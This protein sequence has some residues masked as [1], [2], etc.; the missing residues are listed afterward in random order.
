MKRFENKAAVI[1]GAA[2]GI[3]FEIAANFAS[4]GA[5]TAIAD[6]DASGAVNAAAEIEKTFKT[7]CIGMAADISNAADCEKL[8]EA[9]RQKFGRIDILVNNAGLTKDGL[10]IRMSEND[11]DRVL[12]VNLKGAFFMSKLVSKLMLKQRCGRI[13]NITSVT[14]QMGNAGQ[15]NYSASKAGLIGLTKSMA[16]EF[17]SRQVLVNAVAPGFIATKMTEALPEEAKTR[18]LEMIPLGKFGDPSDVAKL[19]LFLASDEASYITGQVIGV[20]GGMYM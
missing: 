19:V 16:R 11:W 1:T 9:V 5:S 6:I 3:G 10:L 20:N 7:S 12:G 14:G 13:I 8:V 17:A 18:L 15:A 4:E 2:R